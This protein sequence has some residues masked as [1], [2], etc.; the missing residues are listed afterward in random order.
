MNAN[1]PEWLFIFLFNFIVLLGWPVVSLITL[2]AMR[3]R[4]L[5]S[6]PQ[7]LWVLIILAIPFLGA[8]AYWIIKPAENEQL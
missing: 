6:L 4:G 2:I 7:A 8:I 5:S 3:R 1:I